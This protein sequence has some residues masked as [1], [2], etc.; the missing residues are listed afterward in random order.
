LA[1]AHIT[2]FAPVREPR[3][4]RRR[5][6]LPECRNTASALYPFLQI[7]TPLVEDGCQA[8]IVEP[9]DKYQSDRTSPNLRSIADALAANGGQ[10]LPLLDLVAF[11]VAIGNADMH[12]KNLSLTFSDDDSVTL[13]PVYDATSTRLYET[14][15]DGRPVDQELGMRIAG[16]T[17]I[18]DVTIADLVDEA[19]SW[20]MTERLARRGVNDAV[21][22]IRAAVDSVD[23]PLP[24]LRS[25]IAGRIDRLTPRH[26]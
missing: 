12:G 10:L 23:C 16:K 26:H 25:L 4:T 24:D 5:A 11:T 9:V 13:S 20:G 19:R 17:G 15:A 3:R 18:D 1:T 2:S 8:T 22:S 6:P 14:S 21:E 7:R